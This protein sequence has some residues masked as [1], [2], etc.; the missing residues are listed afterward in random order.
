[1]KSVLSKKK[2]NLELELNGTREVLK[3]ADF[4]FGFEKCYCERNTPHPL[5]APGVGSRAIT[6]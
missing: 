6:H 3:N 2:L 4:L 1:M 5:R